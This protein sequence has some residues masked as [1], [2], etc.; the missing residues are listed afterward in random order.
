VNERAHR[1]VLVIIAVALLELGC[2]RDAENRS[3][4]TAAAG[5]GSSVVA[6]LDGAPITAADLADGSLRTRQL[7][8]QR[9]LD[10]V[11]A[12]KLAAREAERRGLD[13][14]SELQAQLAALR[15]EA[16]AREEALLR[17]ALF[18]STRDGLTVSE[19]ELR[20]HYEKTKVRYTE[21]RLRLRHASFP[22]DAAARAADEQLGASGRLDP[23]S[24]E[25][26]GPAAVGALP[27]T[28]LPEALRLREPGERVV[29]LRDS[30]AALVE[31]VEILPA[32]AQSFEDVRPRV[33]RELRAQRAAA[34]FQQLVDGLRAQAQIE[35]DEAALREVDS[36]SPAASGTRSR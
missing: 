8:P 19:D 24:S 17:D 33:E 3:V 22:S 34:S 11:I 32:E 7:E 9:A 20:A 28:V 6:R 35:I 29:V 1:R 5:D 26:I 36:P 30:A 14:A 15:R 27:Q 2:A 10:L 13:D 16:V 12:R 31:L 25:E 23:V 21:R 4:P 18:A